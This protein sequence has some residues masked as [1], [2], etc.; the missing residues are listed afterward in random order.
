MHKYINTKAYIIQFRWH[1]ISYIGSIYNKLPNKKNRL[2]K[3]ILSHEQSHHIEN[4]Y[5]Y[6]SK[7]YKLLD[8]CCETIMLSTDE[9]LLKELVSFL[10]PVMVESGSGY[11]INAINFIPSTFLGKY[12]FVQLTLYQYALKMG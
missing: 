4:K 10:M 8:I 5:S 1:N 2:S 12:F 11:P 6:C 9:S 7:W 3:C